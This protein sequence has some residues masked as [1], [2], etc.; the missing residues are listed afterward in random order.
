M[1][2]QYQASLRVLKFSE[3]LKSFG[4]LATTPKAEYF[5]EILAS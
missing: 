3:Y 4:K 5:I 2:I 1:I